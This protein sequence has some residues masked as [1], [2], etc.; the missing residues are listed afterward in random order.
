MC[1]RPGSFMALEKRTFATRPAAVAAATV[2]VRPGARR[3]ARRRGGEALPRDRTGDA[4]HRPVGRRDR[5]EPSELD[6]TDL[7]PFRAA[8]AAGTPIVMI[9][10]A[11]Y[12]ALDVKPA[13]WSMRI[14]SLLRSDLGFTG[15]TI[16]DA[17]DGAASTRGRHAPVR[18]GARCP[19]GRRSPAPDRERG[20]ER[21]CLR[22]C[23]CRLRNR[24]GSPPL[25]SR[26][27]TVGSWSSSA[28]MARTAA[29]GSHS[30]PSDYIFRRLT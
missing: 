16:S 27:A 8:I 22:A 3:R 19:G 7:V 21:G 4:K 29:R 9:S 10:N 11:T 28:S 14:Q 30:L 2:V 12:P 24:A 15:V 25:H 23:R 6:R 13:P 17:L 20:L 18:R 5:D 1:P 26:R